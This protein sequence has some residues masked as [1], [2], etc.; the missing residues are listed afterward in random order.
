MK[1]LSNKI[2]NLKESQTIAMAQKSRELKAKGLD[3]INLSLGEPDF[4]TPIH[5]QNAAKRAIDE[6]FFHYPPV[7]GYAE[8]R[9]AICQKFK[10]DNNLDFSPDQI[11]VSTGAKQ[12][13]IN[14]LMCI[15]NEGNEVIVPAPYWVSYFEMI[16]L[17][18][19]KPVI[20]Q[21]S[22]EKD[23]KITAE[24]IEAAITPKTKAFLF[25][26]PCNPTGSVYT[27]EELESFAK[28][29][30]K[31]PNIVV[32]SDEIYEYI[33]FGN[34]H[35]SISQFEEILP[36]TVII[37]GMSKA[38]AMTGWR[39]GYLAAPLEIAKACSKIQGQFTSATCGIT[40]QA[41]ITALTGD[42]N[43][44]YKMRDAFEKRMELVYDFLDKMPD[45]KPNYPKGAFYIFPDFSA[46]F[47]KTF[48][49]NLIKNASDL[50]MYLLNEAHVALVTGSAFGNDNCLRISFAA[51]EEQ[52]EKA[53]KRI[54]KAL[55]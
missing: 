54:E 53:L 48:K 49:G 4:D 27:K 16:R 34:Q 52:L 35:E 12:S 19:G 50:S 47:G 1:F 38:F 11:V 30:A 40:Q 37:N 8:L 20:L 3:I 42:M 44:T 33:N 21:S 22:V 23:F 43:P 6:G 9:A 13:I 14:V 51:S 41:A 26:S 36:Q 2:L 31:H 45:V 24:E 7:P 18:G 5:I 32:I 46:F 55:F 25:S 39:L 28:V 17:S 10:R 29:F 15:L